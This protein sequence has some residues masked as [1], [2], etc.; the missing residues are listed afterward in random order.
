MSYMGPDDPSVRFDK[1]LVERHIRK[2]ALTR[3]D[4]EQHLKGLAD[5]AAGSVELALDE[6][7]LGAGKRSS[8]LRLRAAVI[9]QDDGDI[10]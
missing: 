4:L 8:D 10:D 5:Q 7:F 1:R 3:K 2:G 6:H 9:E